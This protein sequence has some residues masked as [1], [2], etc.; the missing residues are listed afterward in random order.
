MTLN[1]SRI[2]ITTTVPVEIIF[3]AG[4]QPVDLNNLFVSDSG[5]SDF[6]HTAEQAGFPQNLCAWIKGIYGIA[7]RRDDIETIIAVTQGDCSNT[8]ALME[9]LEVRGKRII[10][11]D[12][13][14]DRDADML[15]LSMRKLAEKLGTTLKEAEEI[16][17][18]LRPLREK[19]GEL[20]RLTWHENVITGGENHLF[21]VTSSDFNGSIENYEHELDGFLSSVE[22]R[23][24]LAEEVRIGYVGVPPIFSDFYEFLESRGARVVLNEV[25][26]Q[27][28]MPEECSNLV[29]QYSKY[30]YPYDIFGRIEDIKREIERRSIDGIVHYTQSFCFHRIDEIILRERIDLP[31]ITV[32]GDRPQKLDARTRMRLEGFLELV[33]SRK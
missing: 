18:R 25:Q 22:G 23:E 20:D 29:E 19:L 10:P 21:L 17:L 16:R 4:A 13:P 7:S 5:A 12:Y 33:R 26:R 28:S 8:R 32:E 15:E 1:S 3:A 6:L 27:F 11:F 24:P 9:T 2:G 14:Y 30:T 31:I